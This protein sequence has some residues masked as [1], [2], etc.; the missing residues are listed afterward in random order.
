MEKRLRT[1]DGRWIL[2]VL[3]LQTTQASSPRCKYRF[4]ASNVRRDHISCFVFLF[5]EI[6]NY[7]ITSSPSEAFNILAVGGMNTLTRIE[8]IYF[9]FTTNLS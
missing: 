5:C 9:G 6:K 1:Y 3:V 7:F 8:F 4:Y 2:L